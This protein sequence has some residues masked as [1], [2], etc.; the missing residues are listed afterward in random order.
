METKTKMQQRVLL[1]HLLHGPNAQLS[2]RKPIS[3]PLS[4]LMTV[5][6]TG[7]PPSLLTHQT[8]RLLLYQK[9]F[10]LLRN[11]L[12]N[13]KKLITASLILIYTKPLSIGYHLSC[14]SIRFAS[15]S[16]SI[17]SVLPSHNRHLLYSNLPLEKLTTDTNSYQHLTPHLLIKDTCTIATSLSRTCYRY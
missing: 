1:L 16:L 8:S 2:I 3:L 11:L 7:I 15:L 4:L 17:P 9:F 13:F 5:S 10:Y 12:L 14:I 6:L